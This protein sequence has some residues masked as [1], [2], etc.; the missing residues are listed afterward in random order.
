MRQLHISIKRRL[1]RVDFSCR[2]T[3]CSPMVRRN[4]R[5]GGIML[6]R[7]A[8]VLFLAI[9][10]FGGLVNAQPSITNKTVFYPVSG[11]SAAQLRS[12]MTRG[13]P[14]AGGAK[15]YG[16][17]QLR[18]DF[19]VGN[20]QA[21]QFRLTLNF[22]TQLPRLRSASGLS[23]SDMATWNNFVSMASRHEQVHRSIFQS[24]FS[25]VQAK[26]R[27]TGLNSCSG[28][29]SAAQ[30]FWSAAAPDCRRK[31]AAFDAAEKQRLANHPF[32]RVAK[33]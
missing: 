19:N 22:T 20:C 11:S 16:L 8:A 21:S 2:V 27:A 17:T 28:L 14:H 18:P 24:C 33:N 25:S 13:G 3:F 1:A 9:S 31:N 10:T 32:F 29:K 23:S 15:A 7:S 6:G 4:P 12:A 30:R 5:L 26:V